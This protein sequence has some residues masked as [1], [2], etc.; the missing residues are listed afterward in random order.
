MIT[1]AYLQLICIIRGL[2]THFYLLTSTSWSPILCSHATLYRTWVKWGK[3]S[4]FA[5]HIFHSSLVNFMKYSIPISSK[6]NSLEMISIKIPLNNP[7]SPFILDH[8]FK[9]GLFHTDAK[10]K[11]RNRTSISWST[12]HEI[13]NSSGQSFSLSWG[14]HDLCFK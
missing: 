9:L 12:A 11:N 2:T 5:Y 1:V 14:I 8:S 4:L 6:N 13:E 7:F 10:L 3:P